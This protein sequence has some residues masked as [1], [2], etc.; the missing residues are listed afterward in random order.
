MSVCLQNIEFESLSRKWR[1]LIV[2]TEPKG[3]MSVCLGL[4]L[5]E[6][7]PSLLRRYLHHHRPPAFSTG[8]INYSF[9]CFCL[10]VWAKDRGPQ[11]FV[12]LTATLNPTCNNLCAQ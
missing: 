12:G 7:G 3:P 4:G 9:C 2:Q 6:Q 5:A 1:D 10:V 8:I 11:A